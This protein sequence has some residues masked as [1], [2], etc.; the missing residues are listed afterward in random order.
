MFLYVCHPAPNRQKMFSFFP[1]SGGIQGQFSE[2][3]KRLHIFKNL[4]SVAALLA[5]SPHS[6]LSCLYLE[7]SLHF[8]SDCVILLPSPW[9]PVPGEASCLAPHYCGPHFLEPGLGS[10]GPCC[11]PLTFVHRCTAEEPSPAA[12]PS[13]GCRDW[14]RRLSFVLFPGGHV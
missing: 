13:A 4:S 12:G 11:R 14:C 1:T 2:Y 5:S 7:S 10:P 8:L 9:I 6:L 3:E